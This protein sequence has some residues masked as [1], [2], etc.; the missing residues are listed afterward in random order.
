MTKPIS[1]YSPAGMNP[2]RLAG[3]QSRRLQKLQA[4]RV[5][6]VGRGRKLDEAERRQVETRLC[7]EGNIS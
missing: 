6:A 5:A 7:Q 4:G 2:K 1:Q 3:L